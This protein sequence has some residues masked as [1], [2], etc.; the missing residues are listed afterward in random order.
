MRIGAVGLQR[1]LFGDLAVAIDFD[2]P[3]RARLG[4]HHHTVG[5]RLTGMHLVRISR[6]VLPD[7]L[8]LTCH[9]RGA[10]HVREQDIAVGKHPDIYA[11]PWLDTA[12]LSARPYPRDRSCC[13]RSR[14]TRTVCRASN[15][16]ARPLPAHQRWPASRTPRA[17]AQARHRGNDRRAVGPPGWFIT[18]LRMNDDSRGGISDLKRKLPQSCVELTANSIPHPEVVICWLV[19]RLPVQGRHTLVR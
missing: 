11:A 15:A 19:Q 3:H 16:V 7:D 10:L 9:F 8:F 6:F 14:H 18:V 12:R 13:P 2:D 1:D 4:H 17:S 5:K